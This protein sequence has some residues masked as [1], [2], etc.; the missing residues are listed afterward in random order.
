LL[1]EALP[2]EA[3]NAPLTYGNL[4]RIIAVLLQ[5]RAAMHKVPPSPPTPSPPTALLPSSASPCFCSREPNGCGSLQDLQVLDLELCDDFL[6]CAYSQRAERIKL[7]QQEMALLSHDATVIQVRAVGG[8]GGGG[9]GIG[10]GGLLKAGPTHPA[11]ASRGRRAKCL[12]SQKALARSR[13][14]EA[15][16]PARSSP[17]E[18]V[19]EPDATDATLGVP[20]LPPRE[21]EPADVLADASHTVVR[22]GPAGRRGGLVLCG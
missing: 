5:Q 21:I 10:G 18:P 6:R 20:H 12:Q 22:F 3:E 4:N 17:R 1:Q 8:S 2:A 7:L 16:M 15:S 13:M 19:G 9:G 14:A 11:H